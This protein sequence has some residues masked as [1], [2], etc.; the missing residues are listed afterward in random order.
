M[1]DFNHFKNNLPLHVIDFL[2]L[3]H[4]NMIEASMIGGIPRDYLIS[5]TIG[6]DFDICLRP[7]QKLEDKDLFIEI[8]KEKYSKAQE[9]KYGV[10]DLG[11]GIEM[12]WPR[13]E[14]FDHRVGHSNFEVEIIQDLD[15]K[16]DVLRRDFTINAISFTYTGKDFVFKRSSLWS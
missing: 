3:C 2:N 16:K 14:T 9:K 15:Y 8:V 1:I 11:D 7:L 13:I 10:I 6:D 12:S 5:Q 4:E